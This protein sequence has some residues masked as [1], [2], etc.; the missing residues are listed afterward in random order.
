LQ[1]LAKSLFSLLLFDTATRL[2]SYVYT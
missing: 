2:G 1:L